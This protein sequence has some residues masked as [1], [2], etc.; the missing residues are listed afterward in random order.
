MLR[1]IANAVVLVVVYDVI[2]NGNSEKYVGKVK[3]VVRKLNQ[4]LSE[5]KS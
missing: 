5:T 1:M 2:V 3:S 4:S